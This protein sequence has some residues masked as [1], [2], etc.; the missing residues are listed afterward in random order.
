MPPRLWQHATVTGYEELIAALDQAGLW[1]NVD[2]DSKEQAA[3]SA[4]SGESVTWRCG[5]ASAAYGEDL[6]EGTV[7]LLSDCGVSLQVTTLSG[8]WDEGSAGYTVEVNDHT[9]TLYTVDP[10]EPNLPTSEDPWMDCTTKPAALVNR[11]LEAAG[12][13]NRLALFWPGG[14]DGFA[15]LGPERVCRDAAERLSSGSRVDLLIP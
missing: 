6:A 10:S 9:L 2:T 15:V 7:V 1:A 8:P 13:G 3:Q 5:G 11:L 14:N 12:S 4:R